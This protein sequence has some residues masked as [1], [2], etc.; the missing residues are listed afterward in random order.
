MPEVISPT[1]AEADIIVE[2][3]ASFDV[4]MTWTDEVGDLVPIE[5]WTA[6]LQ[7]RQYPGD[8]SLLH[9]MTTGNGMII[10]GGV[11]GTVRLVMTM[12]QTTALDFADGKYQLEL[13]PPSLEAK[14]LLKGRFI[15]DSE[16]V[17]T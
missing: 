6:T 17:T 15:V 3:G 9:E 16:I 4:T 2:Q 11:E 12:A 1:A 10:L 14:R 13:Y 7:V 8:G 5:L